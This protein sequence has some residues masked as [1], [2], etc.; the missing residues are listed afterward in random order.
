[1]AVQR[2]IAED[3]SSRNN[4]V[5]RRQWQVSRINSNY[6]HGQSFAEWRLIMAGLDPFVAV[7]LKIEMPRYRGFGIIVFV[8]DRK[9]LLRLINKTNNEYDRPY[10]FRRILNEITDG[11]YFIR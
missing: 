8:G 4:L 10:F 11:R 5:Y 2:A 9:S 7:Y 6:Q 1:M 3:R